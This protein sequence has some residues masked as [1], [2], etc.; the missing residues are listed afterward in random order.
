M[1]YL[2]LLILLTV[3]GLQIQA[4]VWRINN[5]PGVAAD[6]TNVQ[7]ALSFASVVNGD[8]LHVEGSAVVYAGFTLDKRLVI[9][10]TGYFISGANSNS[11]LQANPFTA[12]F[13]SG[14]ILFDSTGS[15]STLIGLDNFFLGIGANQGSATDNITVTRCNINTLSQYYGYTPGTIMTGWK[16]NKCYIASTLDL[17]AQVVQNWEVTNNIF[18]GSLNLNNTGNLNNLIRNNVFRNS[19]NLYSAYFSNNIITGTTFTTTNVTIKNNLSSGANLPAGNGNLIN[20]SEAA[21]YQG[22]SGNSTDGQWRLNGGS[23]AIGAGETISAITPDC[24]AYGT[25]DPYKLSGIPAIPTIYLLTV[26]ATVPSNATTMPIT[27]S[28]K[29]NN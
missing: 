25:A 26:P 12:N 10:G 14:S 11:G 13:N 7:A 15:G 4:K 3:A 18:Q 5:A 8:T 27:I 29:S 2:S 1:K 23:P 17:T 20:Q 9:I 24:G 16:I 19:I 21:I 6:F 22:I 28:T